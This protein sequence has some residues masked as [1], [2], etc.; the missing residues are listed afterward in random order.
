MHK[1][2]QAKRDAAVPFP[3]LPV[4]YPHG[5]KSQARLEGEIDHNIAYNGFVGWS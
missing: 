4:G 3:M 1:R 5:T 2:D